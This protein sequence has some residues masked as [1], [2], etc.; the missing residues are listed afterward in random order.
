MAKPINS[1]APAAA[2]TPAPTAVW[3]FGGTGVCVGVLVPLVVVEAGA[4]EDVASLVA[5]G[6]VLGPLPLG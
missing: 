3:G 6:V 5:D 4:V 2:P 1:K